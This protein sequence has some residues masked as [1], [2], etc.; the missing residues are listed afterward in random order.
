[1][2]KKV[3]VEVENNEEVKIL[4]SKYK[5]SKKILLSIILIIVVI[6]GIK[7]TRDFIIFEKVMKNN[8]CV[9]LGDNYKI[10]SKNGRQEHILYYKDGVR[11]AVTNSGNN[12]EVV[13]FK[14][15][16][17][18]IMHDEKKYFTSDMSM[19]AQ[20]ST[21]GTEN[22]LWGS[23]EELDKLELLKTMI[24]SFAK[25]RKEEYKGEK[26]ITIQMNMLKL[27]ANPDTYYIEKENVDG[28]IE[29]RT[30]EKDVVTDEDMQV[31]D[32]TGYEE[33]QIGENQ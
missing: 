11:K 29:E 2:E 31:P 32:L 5:K 13:S 27:W 28:Q 7:F 33:I 9:Y 12:H 21:D 3:N 18:F 10:V 23:E 14:D 17:Y 26:Y 4:K 25:V 24:T 15:I 30:I 20:G 6:V 8:I 1:M 16:G 22:I 19:L